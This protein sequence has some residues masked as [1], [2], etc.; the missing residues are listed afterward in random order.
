MEELGGRLVSFFGEK[1]PQG[2]ALA[3]VGVSRVVWLHHPLLTELYSHVIASCWAVHLPTF[4]KEGI[5]F[6]IFGPLFSIEDYHIRLALGQRGYSA[7]AISDFAWKADGNTPGGCSIY[8][9]PEKQAEFTETLRTAYPS[10]VT[11]IKGKREWNGVNPK[12]NWK[13]AVNPDLFPELAKPE[14]KASAA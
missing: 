11:P 2:H 9:T 3:L 10:L 1:D 6:D 12:V 13:K 4:F 8:R 7:V 14:L 5:R